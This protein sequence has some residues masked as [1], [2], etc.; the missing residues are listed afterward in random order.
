[1]GAS[2]ISSTASFEVTTYAG[3]PG[4]G[5]RGSMVQSHGALGELVPVQICETGKKGEEKA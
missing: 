4:A 2:G 1:M 5:V 3:T